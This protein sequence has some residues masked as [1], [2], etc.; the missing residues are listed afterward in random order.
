[1]SVREFSPAPSSL[2]T[3]AGG[4]SGVLVCWCHSQEQYEVY[5]LMELAAVCVWPGEYWNMTEEHEYDLQI[6]KVHSKL[7]Q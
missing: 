7:E 2:Y 4:G 6:Q 5:I 3:P 1:M